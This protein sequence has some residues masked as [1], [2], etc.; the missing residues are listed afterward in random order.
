MIERDDDQSHTSLKEASLGL[1]LTVYTRV[2]FFSIQFL[3][4]SRL[5]PAAISGPL[6]VTS[7]KMFILTDSCYEKDNPVRSAPIN[8]L[9]AK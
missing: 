5:V 2:F 8:A 4:F 7:W 6:L 3:F 9:S 1:F